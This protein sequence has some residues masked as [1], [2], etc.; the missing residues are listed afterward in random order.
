[1]KLT[2]AMRRFDEQ[3]RADGK[4]PITREAY[5]RDVGALA[6]WIGRNTDLKRI[7][8]YRITRYLNSKTFT[9]TATGQLKAPVSLNR[10]KSAIRRFFQFTVEADFVKRN[11]ARLVRLARTQP[12]PPRPMSDADVTKLFS[13]IESDTSPLAERDYVM[14][15]LMLGTGMRLGALVRLDV[16]D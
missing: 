15:R 4:S 16:L 11:P 12:K 5:L 6:N 7:T 13:T 14:F 10:S 3:L 1:M 9:H 2:T 8:P